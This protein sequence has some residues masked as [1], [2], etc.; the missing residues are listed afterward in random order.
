MS[1]EYNA[2]LTNARA[3]YRQAK[4]YGLC[5]RKIVTPKPATIVPEIFRHIRP[6]AMPEHKFKRVCHTCSGYMK[7]NLTGQDHTYHG[8]GC[9]Y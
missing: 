6:H 4:N 8:C 5:E 3:C 7:M 1:K 2:T 9:S